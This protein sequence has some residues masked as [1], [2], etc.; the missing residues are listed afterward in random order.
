MGAGA[1]HHSGQHNGSRLSGR[2][3]GT[4]M[5][6]DTDNLLADELEFR[7]NHEK[8]RIE[9]THPNIFVRDR[10]RTSEPYVRYYTLHWDGREIPVKTEEEKRPVGKNAVGQRIYEVERKVLSIGSPDY[11]TEEAAPPFEFNS[12]NEYICAVNLITKAFSVYG[13][14]AHPR[15]N[16]FPEYSKIDT[17]L[18]ASIRATMY[19]D[20]N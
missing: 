17:D 19:G 15:F 14:F 5:D 6:K 20:L 2:Q 4:A 3:R 9:S 18:S 12:K 10:G 7:V 1:R 8:R 16:I 13:D 11:A